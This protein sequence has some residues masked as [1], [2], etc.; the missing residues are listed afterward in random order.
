MQSSLLKEVAQKLVTSKRVNEALLNEYILN[1]VKIFKD[2]KYNYGGMEGL[3]K[4]EIY[5]LKRIL[6]EHVIF[7]NTRPELIIMK[8]IINNHKPNRLLVGIIDFILSNE[9]GTKRLETFF[10]LLVQELEEEE[11]LIFSVNIPDVK[12]KYTC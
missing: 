10:L 6:K 9:G 2:L 8:K 4:L 1:C 7:L 12:N 5:T 11:A 3:R